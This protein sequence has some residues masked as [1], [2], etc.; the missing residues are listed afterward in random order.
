MILKHA[1]ATRVDPPH[2]GHQ[3]LVGGFN[4]LALNK[5]VDLRVAKVALF[6]AVKDVK[7][8]LAAPVWV[9]MQGLL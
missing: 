7:S 6:L 1:V 9:R 3:L 5:R 2:D 4:T 8:R